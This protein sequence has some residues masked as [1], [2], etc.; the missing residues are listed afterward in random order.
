MRAVSGR[1]GPVDLVGRME[2]GQQQRVQLIHTPA[3]VQSR[4]RRQHVMPGPYPSCWGRSTQDMPVSSTNRMPFRQAR[5]S[6]GSRPG[7][8]ER[9]GRTGTSGWIRVHSSSLTSYL[10]MAT[11]GSPSLSAEPGSHG[12]T[13]H[14]SRPAT[15][16]LL[17]PLTAASPSQR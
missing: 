17:T 11:P 12:G 1:P 2:L 6:S 14:I 8:R 5:S 15:L 7:Q 4:S 16:I 13:G 9:R 3:S 10:A